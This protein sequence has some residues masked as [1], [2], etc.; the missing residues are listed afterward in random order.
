MIKLITFDLDDTL[1]PCFPTIRAAEKKLYTWLEEHAPALTQVHSIDSLREH[2]MAIMAKYPDIAYRLS[3]M[4]LRSFELL[5]K[6]FNLA[7]DLPAA[8][9][10]V[11]RIA[12]NQ[13][14]PYPEVLDLLHSLKPHY[15][16]IAVSNGNAQ[17]PHTPLANCFHGSFS[18]EEVGAAKPDPALFHAASEASHIALK[19]ALH[20]GDDP[21][22]DVV[23][24]QNVGMRTVWINRENRIWPEEYQRADAEMADLNQ[25]SDFLGTARLC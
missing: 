15:T 4:R 7:A 25:L 9:C 5:A 14:T 13:V 6:E 16:L 24:A 22:R 12:R 2:R 21:L 19:H 23:A 3:D 17:V 18:A 11:F 1:W 10:A 8:A 20:I